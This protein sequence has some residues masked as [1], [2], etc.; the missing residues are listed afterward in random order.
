MSVTGLPPPLLLLLLLPPLLFCDAVSVVD[1]HP[2]DEYVVEHEVSY[3][4][5]VKRARSLELYPG[6]IPGC[7][8]CTSDEMSYCAD[9][10]VIDDHCCC[11]NGYNEVLDFVEHTCLVGPEA[12]QVKAGDCA[13]Y[14]RL[15]EC[16]CHTYLASL[17]KYKAG[18]AS[19]TQVTICLLASLPVALGA[20]R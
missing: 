7:K 5:A 8:P 20:V 3:Q 6:P 17:W 1:H 10:R 2:D 9:Q 14:S 19:G 11:D 18:G 12:C 4:Q 15:R 16:C 13:E